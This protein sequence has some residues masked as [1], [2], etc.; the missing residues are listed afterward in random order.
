MRVIGRRFN[1][2]EPTAPSYDLA[3]VWI[4]DTQLS[5]DGNSVSRG[6]SW[7]PAYDADMMRFSNNTTCVSSSSASLRGLAGTHRHPIGLGHRSVAPDGTDKT[8][9]AHVA[10]S[11]WISWISTILFVEMER[12]SSKSKSASFRLW[13]I[14]LNVVALLNL[15][16]I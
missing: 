4:G 6:L 10:T 13:L 5:L 7:R 1:Q 2:I 9:A 14:S 16:G 3:V 11:H 15:N 8:G 12:K